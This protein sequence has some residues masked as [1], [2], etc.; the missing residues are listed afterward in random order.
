MKLYHGTS[1]ENAI[2]ILKERKL[3]GKKKFDNHLYPYISF[4]KDKRIAGLFGEVVF[5]FQKA[6]HVAEKVHYE[7]IEWMISNREIC[8]YISGTRMV[9]FLEESGGGLLTM[10]DEEEYFIRGEYTFDFDE[11]KIY[12]TSEDPGNIPLIAKELQKIT[13]GKV[14]IVEDEELYV[15]AH[16]TIYEPKSSLIDE[17]TK[18]EYKKKMDEYLSKL[19]K[20]QKIERMDKYKEFSIKL[21]KHSR[22][23]N[24]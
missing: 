18:L 24:S 14:E 4:S 10:D 5:E 12:V 19:K 2:E 20:E 1:A 7:D 23:K 8:E 15:L 17:K 13:K 21:E 9:D 6:F 11:I 22:L 16:E 3:R